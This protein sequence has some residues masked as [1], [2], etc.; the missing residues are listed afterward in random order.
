MPK[1]TDLET[2]DPVIEDNQDGTLR[3]SGTVVTP[4]GDVDKYI[5]I[6]SD[7]AGAAFVRISYQMN[8]ER[9]PL[10]SLRLGAVTLNPEAFDPDTLFFATHNGGKTLETFALESTPVN[11]GNPASFLVSANAGLGVTEGVVILGDKYRQ[12]NIT[13]DKKQSAAIG[14]VSFRKV[15]PNYFF[16]HVF[17]IL[18]MDETS[19]KKGLAGLGRSEVAITLKAQSF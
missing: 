13:I 15:F 16:R 10:G 12:L 19:R 14:M 17:S 8:W 3:I 1:I 9:K 4:L 18:E 2:V 5:E 7:E 11:H 6:S